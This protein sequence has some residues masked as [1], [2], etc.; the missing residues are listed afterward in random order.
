MPIG[1]QPGQSWTPEGN[2]VKICYRLIEEGI[3]ALGHRVNVWPPIVTVPTR[4]PDGVGGLIATVWETVPLPLPPTPVTI[5]IQDALL[6]AIHMCQPGRRR[7]IY[8]LPAPPAAPN[9]LDIGLIA[10]VQPVAW[11]IVNVWLPDVVRVP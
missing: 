4:F 11:L 9:I 10:N 1:W 3:R 7:D 8:G 2:K 6:T 5:V